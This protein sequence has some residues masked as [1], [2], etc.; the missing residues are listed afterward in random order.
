[1]D[2]A[3]EAQ[4]WA[5]RQAIQDA[6]VGVWWPG[7]GEGK[8]LSSRTGPAW[9]WIRETLRTL[10]LRACLRGASHDCVSQDHSLPGLLVLLVSAHPWCS[11][12]GFSGTWVRRSKSVPLFRFLFPSHNFSST[13]LFTW[14]GRGAVMVSWCP[15]FPRSEPQEGEEV[16]TAHRSLPFDYALL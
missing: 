4:D 14:K 1:M 3:G 7:E 2:R 5:A 6:L 10:S 9:G 16:L 8:V 11:V 15:G 13:V 12:L